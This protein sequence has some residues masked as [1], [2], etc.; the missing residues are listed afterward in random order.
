MSIS[1]NDQRFFLITL[2]AIMNSGSGYLKALS[3]ISRGEGEIAEIAKKMLLKYNANQDIYEAFEGFDSNVRMVAHAAQRSGA[4]LPGLESA[5]DGLKVAGM[6]KVKFYL[7]MTT[8]V[9]MTISVLCIL[10]FI[11]SEFI[12]QAAGN[13]P[14]SRWPVASL[15]VYSYSNFVGKWW[16]FILTI[17]IVL[18]S[19]YRWSLDNWRV[20]PTRQFF[21]RIIPGYKLHR[22]FQAQ[23]FLETLYILLSVSN[24]LGKNLSL[25]K[26]RGSPYI[27]SHIEQMIEILVAMSNTAEDGKDKT[28]VV[29]ILDTGLL[30]VND[31]SII[32]SIGGTDGGDIIDGI[33]TVVIKGRDF[34]PLVLEKWERVFVVITF[35]LFLI[36]VFLFSTSV[37]PLFMEM[38]IYKG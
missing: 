14:Q 7:S 4:I 5:I 21:E 31:M 22:E 29:K 34:L 9:I 10:Y 37:S 17:F 1:K 38:S 11:G 12:P 18:Y 24:G 15:V 6:G 3:V 13:L 25:M 26:E 33:R 30:S 8:P 20:S 32:E 16:A 35:I 28:G 36:S 2:C 19:A 23:S 27:R